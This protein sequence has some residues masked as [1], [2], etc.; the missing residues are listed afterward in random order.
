MLDTLS[1]R[2]LRFVEEYIKDSSNKTGAAVR[3]GYSPSGALDA[4]NRILKK[5]EAKKVID[6]ANKE[7]AATLG[8]TALK[9]MSELASIAFAKP[10]TKV[11]VD[12][13]GQD[14]LVVESLDATEVN[15]TTSSSGGKKAKVT[16][17]KTIRNADKIAALGLIAKSMGIM[18]DKVEVEHSGSLI[19]LI[20]QSYKLEEKE[21]SDTSS[22]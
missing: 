2:E 11:V 8:I 15:V 6:D 16:S 14:E 17:V 12:E 3:A 22:G 18:K 21:N 7:A 10:G 20:E 1:E 19:D 5:P 9:V 4:A 13:D